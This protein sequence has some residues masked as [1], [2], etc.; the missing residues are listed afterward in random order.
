ME[1]SLMQDLFTQAKQDN[2]QI[3]LCVLD[4]DSSSHNALHD[5]FP[6]AKLIACKNHVTKNF[7]NKLAQIANECQCLSKCKKITHKLIK[8]AQKMLAKILSKEPNEE[9]F[10]E[11]VR[12]IPEHY[13]N[14][15]SKC[16]YHPHELDGKP[17]QAEVFFSCQS[18]LEQFRKIVNVMADNPREYLE[19]E[20]GLTTNVSEA[21]AGLALHF[22][23]NLSLFIP[24]I[25]F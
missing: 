6:K 21:T 19:N 22:R 17:F 20:Q 2:F 10:A 23:I 9:Q 24:I 4:G 8:K 12:N 16:Q 1:G 15:H 18:Q 11:E 3:S 5:I 13:S 14:N 7:Y 25:M